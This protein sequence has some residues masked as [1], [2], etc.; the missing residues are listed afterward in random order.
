MPDVRFVQQNDKQILLIDLVDL[1]DYSA[2]PGLVEKAVRLAQS[3]AGPGSVRTLIDL[4]GSRINKEIVS[5]LKNL[6]KNNGRYA[7]ATAF[8]GLGKG[9]S[10][11]LTLMFRAR[12][13]DNH[14]VLTSRQEALRWLEKW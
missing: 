4:N 7:K 10:L 5:S 11:L 13:K 1:S 14:K 12:G 2:V 6:S 9:W 3:S 8:V